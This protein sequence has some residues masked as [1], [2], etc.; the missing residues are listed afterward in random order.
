[1]NITTDGHKYLGSFIGNEEATKIF[2]EE[3]VKEWTKDIDAL[4]E[5]AQSEPQLAYN[6]YVFGTSRRWQFVCRTTP[7]IADYLIHF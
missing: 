4:A 5:I 3:K 1:M 7:G 6:A 2:I